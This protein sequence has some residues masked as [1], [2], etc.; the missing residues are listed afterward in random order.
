MVPDPD[1]EAPIT[2]KTR[3]ADDQAPRFSWIVRITYRE[4]SY[5]QRIGTD[6]A[7]SHRFA[8]VAANEGDAIAQAKTEFEK[9]AMRSGVSWAREIER[10]EC[11]RS[12]DTGRDGG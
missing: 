3:G 4:P 10:I 1:D 9:M 5:A 11:E 8:V 7:Y 6:T 2:R 12:R